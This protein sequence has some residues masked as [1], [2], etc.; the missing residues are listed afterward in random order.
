MQW[1]VKKITVVSTEDEAEG[2]D[3]NSAMA[4]RAA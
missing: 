2:E 4:T 1:N 3:E